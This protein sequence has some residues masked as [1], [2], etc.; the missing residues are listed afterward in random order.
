MFICET[1]LACMIPILRFRGAPCQSAVASAMPVSDAR[2][3][4]LTQSVKSRTSPLES[5]MTTCFPEKSRA[6]TGVFD[7]VDNRQK[8]GLFS[9]WL[10][11]HPCR[12]ST[13][14]PLAG[15]DFFLFE[16]VLDD[17]LVGVR[18]AGRQSVLEK[19]PPQAPGARFEN[20]QDPWPRIGVGQA[21][22]HLGDGRGMVGEILEKTVFCS[23]PS[24]DSRRSTPLNVASASSTAAGGR[25]SSWARMI[26]AVR[27]QT[28]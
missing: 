9:P 19:V 2:I 11:V 27:F 3:R 26:P 12:A 18:Q 7:P 6:P 10:P 16:D 24:G 4:S 15:R 13:S 28:L 14:Q 21:A 20:D 17:D 8:H 1:S 22:Q 5:R 23:W 25:P